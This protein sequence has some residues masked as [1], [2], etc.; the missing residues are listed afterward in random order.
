MPKPG[1]VRILIGNI[2]EKDAEILLAKKTI[3][4]GA[5]KGAKAPDGPT[6]EIK[7]GSYAV[8]VKSPGL[9]A[10]PETITVGA[11]EIWGLMIGPGG[12][13]ALPMY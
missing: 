2:L 9:N 10:S 1:Q 8:N 6:L 4:V 12:I 5:G 7:P 13:L 3:K 11:D